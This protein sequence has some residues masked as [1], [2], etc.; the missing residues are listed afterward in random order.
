[1][2]I[3]VDKFVSNIIPESEFETVFREASEKYF[4]DAKTM[5]SY[6]MSKGATV[7]LKQVL[8]KYAAFLME[9]R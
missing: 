2:D 5:F 9:K 6:A 7:K 8:Q 3:T 4:I 1:M